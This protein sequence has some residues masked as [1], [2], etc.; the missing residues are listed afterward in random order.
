VYK[1][2]LPPLSA[3][4]KRKLNLQL[5]E[6]DEKLGFA[7]G[8][9]WR[10]V[11]SLGMRRE[12]LRSLI[13]SD[14]PGFYYRPTCAP[15]RNESELKAVIERHQ[16]D[17][18]VIDLIG[19]YKTVELLVG[20]FN[21]MAAAYL[22]ICPG[23]PG[24]YQRFPK[25]LKAIKQQAIRRCREKWRGRG[26]WFNRMPLPN[27]GAELESAADAWRRKARALEESALDFV[28]ECPAEAVATMA[29]GSA[30]PAAA[31]K[32]PEPKGR[33]GRPS[34]R[35]ELKERAL[36]KLNEL[37]AQGKK[38]NRAIARI[39]YDIRNPTPQ[40]SRSVPTI[41]GYYEQNQRSEYLKALAARKTGRE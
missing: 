24:R 22:S 37:K 11:D 18:D 34:I 15:I 40:Q 36:K 38:N 16:N 35:L 1:L 32:S 6:L 5:E 39:L 29:G 30:Q 21:T 27:A 7:G 14:Y 41:L 10:W 8:D 33:R 17:P 20:T 2:K 28:E 19:V 23:A 13:G 25:W 4:G 26:D 12:A 3:D 9:H 31:V